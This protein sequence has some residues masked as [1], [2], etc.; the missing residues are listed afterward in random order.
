MLPFEF[1]TVYFSVLVGLAL[2]NILKAISDLIEIRSRV[3]V[4]WVNSV[5]VLLV[6][7]QCIYAWW[8]LWELQN[9]DYWNYLRFL[10]V[11]ANLSGFYMMTTLVLPK[12]I[13]SGRVDLREHYYF[14]RKIFFATFFFIL[15]TSALM[16]HVLFL[17]PIISEFTIIPFVI[18]LFALSAVFIKHPKYHGILSII[19]LLTLISFMGLDITIIKI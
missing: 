15:S 17:K 19:F 8:G 2:S 14:V 3:K 18:S 1:V 10:L 12:A 4:Y 5:W 7:I 9:L 13:E 6:V 16:N 11:V